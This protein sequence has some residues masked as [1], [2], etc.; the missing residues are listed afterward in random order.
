MHFNTACVAGVAS[1]EALGGARGLLGLILEMGSDKRYNFTAMIRKTCWQQ[2]ARSI[3]AR[4]ARDSN[5]GSCEATE[6]GLA[7]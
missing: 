6:A 4:D 3:I 2:V 1:A 7:Y 5:A